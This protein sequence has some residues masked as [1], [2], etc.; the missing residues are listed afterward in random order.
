MHAIV[1]VMCLVLLL[2]TCMAACGTGAQPPEP[3]ATGTRSTP[4]PAQSRV[5]LLLTKEQVDTVIPGHDGGSNRD[6]SEASLLR[7][8]RLEHCQYMLVRNTDLRL[9]DVLIYTTTSDAG[10]ES[11]P[12]GLKRCT[13]DGCRQLDLGDR[14]FAAVRNGDP[15]VVVIKGRQHMEL[16]LSGPEAAAK[17]DALVELARVAARGL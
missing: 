13:S 7:D 11:L 10:A 17:S 6:T 5:C 1:R 2:A 4:D 15:R 12:D 3:A 14:S 16:T 8:V 9:L